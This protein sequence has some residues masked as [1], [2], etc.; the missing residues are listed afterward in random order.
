MY[1]DQRQQLI[2]YFTRIASELITSTLRSPKNLHGA[3][4]RVGSAILV[5]IWNI[6]KQDLG[7]ILEGNTFLHTKSTFFKR[8][9]IYQI[10]VFLFIIPDENEKSNSADFTSAHILWFW[11]VVWGCDFAYKMDS[12]SR[13][14]TFDMSYL[15]IITPNLLGMVILNEGVSDAPT[16]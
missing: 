9:E 15:K 2:K 16:N 10:V 4:D 3:T 11:D 1:N 7:I 14:V 8:I 5:R 6:S 13:Y 12:M